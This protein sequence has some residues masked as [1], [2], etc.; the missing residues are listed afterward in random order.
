VLSDWAAAGG[1][2]RQH[3]A[4]P[5]LL[6]TII[7]D[8]SQGFFRAIGKGMC[9]ATSKTSKAA[10]FSKAAALIP[11][12]DYNHSKSLPISEQDFAD[13]LLPDF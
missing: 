2:V 11:F 4:C 12:H 9:G 7:E 6:L 13:S 8:I 3:L 10:L 1:A 5:S